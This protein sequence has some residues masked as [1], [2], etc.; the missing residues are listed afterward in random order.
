[1]RSILALTMLGSMVVGGSG[2]TTVAK[3]ALKEAAGASSKARAVPGLTSSSLAQC[4]GISVGTP[5]SDL[6]SLVDPKFTSALPVALRDSLTGGEEP[7]FRGGSPT[8]EIDSE[9]AWYHEA[10]GVG[11]IVGSDSYVVVLFWLSVDGAPMGKVQL[12]TK[13][14]ASRTGED[15]MAKSMAK[16]LASFLKKH[17]KKKD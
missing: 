14:A 11:G 15:D 17:R 7:L 4:Q 3:R 16:G 8:L 1:M 5:R 10:G 6:G 13:S 12:V 2:C 9:I